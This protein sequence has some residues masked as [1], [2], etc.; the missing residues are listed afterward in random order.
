MTTVVS[1]ESVTASSIFRIMDKMERDPV[2]VLK[3]AS[4]AN[5]KHGDIMETL[6]AYCKV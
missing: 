5:T 6:L 4:V 1:E 3:M 2:G